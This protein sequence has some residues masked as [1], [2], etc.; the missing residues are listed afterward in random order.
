MGST[1]IDAPEVQPIDIGQQIRETAT[2]YR[3]ATPDIVAAERALRGPM[4]QLALQD[5]QTALM[6]GVTPFAPA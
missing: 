4:Q 3:Q 2:A 1:R 6:G 5:A